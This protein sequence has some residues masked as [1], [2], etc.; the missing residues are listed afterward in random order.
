MATAVVSARIDEALKDQVDFYLQ[1]AGVGPGDVIRVVWE[2]IG[3]THKVPQPVVE[4]PA[5]DYAGKIRKVRGKMQQGDNS[6]LAAMTDAQMRDL[7][8][9]RYA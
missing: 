2:N 9:D 1:M 7:L 6:F 3:K 8:A 4:E 5:L